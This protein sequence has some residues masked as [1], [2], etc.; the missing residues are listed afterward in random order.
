MSRIALGLFAFFGGIM[1][2]L[3]VFQVV[4]LEDFYKG[5]KVH[6]VRHNASYIEKH[7]NDDDIAEI[8][9]D[10]SMKND[11]CIEIVG[12]DGRVMHSAHSDAFCLIHT[13]HPEERKELIE[14]AITDSEPWLG[15][16]DK[17]GPD[18]HEEHKWMGGFMP[19]RAKKSEALLYRCNMDTDDGKAV[20]LVNATI[21]PVKATVTTI[22]LQLLI[23][24]IIALLAGTAFAWYISRKVALPI[25]AVN[26]QAKQLE[27]GNYDVVFDGKGYREIEELSQ[28]LTATAKELDKVE[29]L[30]REL[31]ANVSHDLRTPLTLISGYA[32]M[33]RDLPGENTPENAAVII[34]ETKRLTGLVTDLLDMSKLQ[35]G[36][37][38]L[39]AEEFSVTDMC[40][41]VIERVSAMLKAEN[42]CIS[43]ENEGDITVVADRR[44]ITQAFYNLLTNAVNYTGDDKKI[45]VRQERNGERVRI[46]VSDTGSGIPEDELPYI[47]DRYYKSKNAHKRAKIGTG[48]GLSIVRSAVSLNGGKYGV[49]SK[50]GQGSTFWFEI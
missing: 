16:Y 40:R 13:L 44:M 39:N 32:E 30:R 3:W 12:A 45:V 38:E 23:V 50:T 35:S 11:V 41:S 5:V 43:F 8:T 28:T 6:Q 42:Y 24:G 4:F 21:E 1:V 27:T 36:A 26:R 47:W 20:L 37:V 2:I 15:Y 34:D 9:E 7:I 46:S 25:I 22:R 31:I 19:H 18:F 33:M 48:L 14:R 29:G 49:S 10:I 17:K